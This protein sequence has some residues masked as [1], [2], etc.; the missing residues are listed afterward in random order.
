MCH[1]LD[2]TLFLSVLEGIAPL[3]VDRYGMLHMLAD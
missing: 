3:R 2:R 1:W